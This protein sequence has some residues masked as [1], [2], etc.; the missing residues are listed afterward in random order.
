MRREFG[1]GCAL[2]AIR[3]VHGDEN[4]RRRGR[5]APAIHDENVG[6]AHPERQATNQQV[7]DYASAFLF[8]P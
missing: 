2:E 6:T 1:F 7:L 4:E 5:D 3:L 8:L